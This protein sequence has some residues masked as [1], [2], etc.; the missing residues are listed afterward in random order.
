MC[1]RVDRQAGFT[2][3][4]VLV[5]L[6]VLAIALAAIIQSVAASNNN[7]AYLR[8]RTLAHWVAMNRIA[9]VQSLRQ[10][11]DLGSD[12]GSEEMANHEWFWRLDVSDAGIEGVRRLEVSVRRARDDRQ[13]LARLTALVGRPQP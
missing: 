3:M 11:P 8:D 5:A 12:T 7:T 6:A 13:A 9:E 10:W 4:E 2:L 1:R